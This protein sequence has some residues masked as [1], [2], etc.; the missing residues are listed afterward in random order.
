MSVIVPSG[1]SLN[2][3]SLF[4]TALTS[5]SLFGEIRGS[6][7]IIIYLAALKSFLEIGTCIVLTSTTAV[8]GV[9]NNGF[10]FSP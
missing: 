9:L 10:D 7:V 2:I 6:P 8:G 5:L 3:L 1:S 4:V